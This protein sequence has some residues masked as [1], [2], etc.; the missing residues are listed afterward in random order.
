MSDFSSTSCLQLIIEW[1]IA[2]V[3][4]I[5]TLFSHISLEAYLGVWSKSQDSLMAAALT[6]S[7]YTMTYCGSIGWLLL[8]YPESHS[9]KL[10]VKVCKTQHNNVENVKLTELSSFFVT[11]SWWE[12]G[13]K[14]LLRQNSVWA[15]RFVADDIADAVQ[16]FRLK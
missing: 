9:P 2:I 15:I 1:A 11:F 3:K 13:I 5:L 4:I 8:L 12:S 7:A 16:N 6:A 14:L 10:T